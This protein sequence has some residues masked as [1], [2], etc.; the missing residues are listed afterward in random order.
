ML[1]PSALPVPLLA[2]VP[3]LL[4]F[5]KRDLSVILML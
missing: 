5:C 1:H 4:S 2:L 3:S